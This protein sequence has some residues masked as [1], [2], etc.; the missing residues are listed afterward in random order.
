VEMATDMGPKAVEA[1]GASDFSVVLTAYRDAAAERAHVMLP[2]APYAESS[3]TFV[4]MEGRAQAFNACVKPQADARPAWKVLRVLG[5]LLELPGFNAETL[6]EVRADICKS[7]GAADLQAW[8]GNRLS[9]EGAG[10]EWEVRARASRLERIAEF[11]IYATDPIVRR[12][13]PLQKTADGKA[14]RTARLNPATFAAMGLAAGGQVR[15]RQGGGEALLPAVADANVPEGCVR[16]ARGV[17]ETAALGE[18]ELTVEAVRLEA[19]A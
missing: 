13:P 5:S 3:G 6:E 12:S 19:V 11:P 8:V 1:L 17:A 18:G 2:I 9:N 7:K 4:N 14:A 10:V 16:V 15:V